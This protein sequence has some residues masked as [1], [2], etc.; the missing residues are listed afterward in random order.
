MIPYSI[1]LDHHGYL[2]HCEMR[3][4][5]GKQVS[6]RLKITHITIISRVSTVT[7]LF[8][9]KLQTNIGSHYFDNPLLKV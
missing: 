5:S 6:I 8:A 4:M 1:R 2:R 7:V 9:P 3:H